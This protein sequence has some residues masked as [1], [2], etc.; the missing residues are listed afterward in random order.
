VKEGA[1]NVWIDAEP[2]SQ[3]DTMLGRSAGMGFMLYTDDYE[4]A[5]RIAKFLNDNVRQVMF[6]FFKDHPMFNAGGKS[7]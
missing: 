4:E 3:T 6:F 5:E 7:K 1:N 2:Q